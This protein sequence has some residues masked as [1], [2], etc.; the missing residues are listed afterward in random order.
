[1]FESGRKAPRMSELASTRVKTASEATKSRPLGGTPSNR[2][3]SQ[4]SRKKGKGGAAKETDL[5]AKEE[6][7]RFVRESLQHE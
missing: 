6:E 4:P 2:P 5:K 3:L 1:M 7:Y